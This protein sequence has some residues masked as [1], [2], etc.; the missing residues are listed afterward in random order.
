MTDQ[1]PYTITSDCPIACLA[2][3]LTPRTL[4]ILITGT[5]GSAATVGQVV[6]IYEKDELRKVFGIGPSRYGEICWALVQTALVEQTWVS[7]MKRR[8]REG[9]WGHDEGCRET[10]MEI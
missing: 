1:L 2:P 6:E 8:V 9:K 3:L 7:Y 10:T 4:D 5:E